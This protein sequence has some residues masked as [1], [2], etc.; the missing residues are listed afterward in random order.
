MDRLYIRMRDL[1]GGRS[2]D[3][4]PDDVGYYTLLDLGDLSAKAFG[5]PF[6]EWLLRTVEPRSLLFELAKDSGVVLLPGT[7]FGGLTPAGRVSL[8]NLNETDYAKIGKAARAL[9]ERYYL[10]FNS[11]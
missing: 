2:P 4:N 5:K 3:A 10:K 9:I 11:N 8:A 1:S 6:A 7:G